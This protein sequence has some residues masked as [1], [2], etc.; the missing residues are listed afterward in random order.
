[1]GCTRSVL[2]DTIVPKKVILPEFNSSDE[3]MEN[4]N[5]QKIRSIG[6]G[7]YAEIFLIRSKK[8]GREYALKAII[9]DNM[10]IKMVSN[11]M[12]EVDNLKI[13]DHPNIISFKCAFTSNIK[14]ELLNIMTE[15]ADNGD[16]NRKLEENRKEKKYF[17]ENQLLDC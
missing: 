2:T 6:K 7:N 4:E 15:Y 14:T 1:M 8:T 3:I 13:L 17:E 16:L 10:N 11:I 9:I 5:F 12:R